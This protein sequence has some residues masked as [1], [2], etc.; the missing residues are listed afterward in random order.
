LRNRQVAHKEVIVTIITTTPVTR[1]KIVLGYDGSAGAVNALMYA[2]PLA[3]QRSKELVVLVALPHLSPSNTRT[4]RA[5]RVDP[6]YVEMATD[7]AMRQLAAVEEQLAKQFPALSA[8]IALLPLDPAGA[9]ADASKDAELVVVGARGKNSESRAPIL[10]GVSGNVIAHSQGPVMVVPDGIHDI[11]DG[12]VVV[13]LQ[14]APDSIAAGRI[15][16]AEAEARG[17][18]LVALYA[19]D[20]APEIGDMGAI[21]LLDTDQTRVELDQMLAELLG[22]LLEGHPGVKAERRVVQGSARAALVDASKTASLLVIGSRGLGGFAGL[23]LGSISRS[24]T[25]ESACPVI[26]TRAQR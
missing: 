18:P 22:P 21:A 13:G 7:R 4:A 24:V 23:L 17:V 9:L 10:G 5:L 15:A 16:V 19:W 14:D 6:D 11:D 1:G 20:F 25:R 2:A 12:P 26:V 3:I 8:E